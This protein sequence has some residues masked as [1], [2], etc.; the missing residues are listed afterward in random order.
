MSE[1]EWEYPFTEDELNDDASVSERF[2]TQRQLTGL[3]KLGR[4]GE[5]PVDIRFRESK[6][7]YGYFDFE[8]KP[9]GAAEYRP[10]RYQC[11]SF[12]EFHGFVVG[13]WAGVRLARDSGNDA[14]G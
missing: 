5:P 6:G 12:H 8:V 7:Q 2:W 14:S 13:I 10:T 3:L 1:T 4:Y 9:P 11:V